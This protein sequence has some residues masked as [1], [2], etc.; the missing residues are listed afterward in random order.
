MTALTLDHCDGLYDNAPS[1]AR[2]GVEQVTE[3][4]LS[5][6]SLGN[7]REASTT[8]SVPERGG[9]VFTTLNYVSFHCR[10]TTGYWPFHQAV[11]VEGLT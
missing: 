8:L 11:A 1:P 3:V 9:F 2:V 5:Y 6:R 7:G 4:L 10:I